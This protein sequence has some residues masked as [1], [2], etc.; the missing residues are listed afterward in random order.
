[1]EYYLVI[2]T[3]DN[4][5][6]IKIKH[7]QAGIL[8]TILTRSCLKWYYRFWKEYANSSKN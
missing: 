2:K 5:I 4:K 1:M 3:N 7:R 8:T 6:V